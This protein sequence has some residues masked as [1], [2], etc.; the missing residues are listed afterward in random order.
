MAT[1]ATARRKLRWFARQGRATERKMFLEPLEQ[2][3]LLATAAEIDTAISSGLAWLAT[4]QAGD[5]RFGSGSNPV[6]YTAAAVLAFENEGHFPG[7]G[8]TYSTHVERGLD[9]MFN[10]AKVG[11][12]SPQLHGDPDTDHDGVYVSFWDDSY[13]REV[14]E[15]GMVM[16]AIV[17]SN[18][19]DRV[20]TTGPLSGWTYQDVMVDLVDWAAF[21]QVDAGTGRGGWRYFANYGNSDNS[22]AQWP[23]LGLVAAEQWGI[24]APQFVKDELNIWIDY[25][26]NDFSGGSGYDN[27][28]TY[29]NVSKTGGLLVE[30]YYVGDDCQVDRA[31]DALGFIN[32]R[33]NDPPN[34]TWYGN[35]G[36]SYAMFSVFKGLELMQVSTIPNAPANTETPAGDWYGD[37][38]DYLVNTQRSN[39]SWAGYSNW[40]DWLST[41]WYVVILQSTVFPVEVGVDAPSFAC[42]TL[43]YE[44]EVDYSVQRF[45]ADGTVTVS[46]DGT[47]IDT[48]VLDDFQGSGTVSVFMATDSPGDHEWSAVLDVTGGGIHVVSQHSDTVTV[49]ETPQVGDIPDQVAPFTPFDLDDYVTYTGPQPLTWAATGEP[50]GWM[51]DIDAEH[52]VTVTAPPEATEHAVLTFTASIGCPLGTLV[53]SDSDNATFLPFTVEVDGPE[54]LVP[55]QPFS[56]VLG[57]NNPE[58][59]EEVTYEIDWDGDGAF[60]QT[61]VGPP[62]DFEVLHGYPLPGT[63]DVIVR[64]SDEEGHTTPTETHSILVEQA[65]VIDG[66]LCVG[67]TMLSDRII[68]Y[69]M[70]EPGTYCCRVNTLTLGP[71]RPDPDCMMFAFGCEGDDVITVSGSITGACCLD[72]GPGNDYLAGGPGPDE[73]IGGPGDD[74]LLGGEG[75]N[76]LYGGEGNDRLYGRD[77]VDRM[78]GGPG[79]DQLVGQGGN[80]I[81]EGEEGDDYLDGGFGDDIL[82]GGAGNDTLSGYYGNDFLLGGPGDDELF[83]RAGN[84][85]LIGGLGADRIRGDSGDDLLVAGTTDQDNGSD[86]ALMSLLSAWSGH[87]NHL[88]GITADLDADLL[89]GD[90]GA[91]EFWADL[92]PIPALDRVYDLNAV[93]AVFEEL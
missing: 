82:R 78:F 52:V 42:D 15:T 83:G 70:N 81:L 3:N 86:A 65:M 51:V 84:D 35:K 79:N 41:G 58:A 54:M 91:D 48:V 17:A 89:I 88:T 68:I 67:G 47:V 50:I 93:D 16:Q 59:F 45:P 29:V 63:Y 27:P 2:R 53:C 77:G 26:Q 34:G 9:F 55:C 49:L 46:R 10:Y 28:T 71:F 32:S 43:G 25:V 92:L 39:G 73:L 23:V 56:L 74:R 11:A 19:P 36:H 85:I 20:V 72:G 4:Q 18:T 90:L 13:S 5:G 1:Q 66:D 87:V 61:V 40:N 8:N 31:E 62:E 64:A 12:I 33:W 38:A 75:D 21:G 37:Y 24:Q 22:T 80:D 14:Y 76:V 7:G 44:V 60:D 57:V 6:A 69:P 30:M